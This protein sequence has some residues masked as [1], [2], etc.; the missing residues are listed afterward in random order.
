[1]RLHYLGKDG[2]SNFISLTEKPLTIGRSADADLM[3]L[4]EKASRVHCGIRFWDGE[5]FIKDLKSKNGT[6][7]NDARVDI[8]QLNPGDRIRVGS[9]VFVFERESTGTDT[10]LSAM[11]DAFLGGKGYS[12]I[13]REIVN[14]TDPSPPAGAAAAGDVDAAPGTGE[15]VEPARIAPPRRRPVLGARKGAGAPPARKPLKVRIRRPSP[16]NGEEGD[17][18]PP[19]DGPA[20][21]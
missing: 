8:R 16:K 17:A 18:A 12:T 10:A 1:M 21:E 13:L 2:R 20:P 4:D 15:V 6:Y 5:F 3:I 14:E 9:T 7:V 11:Q 19:A